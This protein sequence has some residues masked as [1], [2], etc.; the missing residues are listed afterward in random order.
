M[1]AER[2]A[3]Q[4]G[5][6]AT[7]AGGS[8]LEQAIGATKQTKRSEAESMIRTLVDEVNKGTVKF[9]RNLNRTI[10]AGIA[11]IDRVVSEQLAAV[12]H[13]EDFQKLEGSWRGLHYLVQNSET[14]TA[15]KLR[16]LNCTKRELFKDLDR[17]VEF[18]QSDLFKKIY[19]NE[20]G[21][22]GGEPYGALI[23]DYQFSNHPEDIDLLSKISGVA[24]AGFCPF[25]TS[26]SPQLF[27]MDDWEELSKPRDLAKIFDASEYIKWNS[28]R[29]SDDSRF[30]TMCMPRTLARLP[31]GSKT[32]AIDEFG[33]EEVPLGPKGE[34]ISVSHDQY[35]WMNTAYVMG[36]RLTDA[37]AKN[38][39]CTAI[40]GAE[41][42][43][44]VDDLPSFN[45]V[46]GF[47]RE[48]IVT[49]RVKD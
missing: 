25:L 34:S 13:H 33:Y 17:A 4:A 37:F 21:T 32:K 3:Q 19:E 47:W 44:R 10:S 26:P 46:A 27:G 12:M 14:G 9:D 23:G 48:V 11:E 18:D 6:S 49:Y 7:T 43:G 35:C 30:V 45:K 42:G 2:E 5:S 39:W 29:D 8:L 41:N 40:R 1:A 22:A 20:F 15:L 36:A 28:F 16:V 31:Y 24:A 38:G